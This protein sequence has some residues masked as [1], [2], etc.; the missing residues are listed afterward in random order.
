MNP[1]V[2]LRAIFPI[3]ESPGPHPRARAGEGGWVLITT[4][5]TLLLITSLG[6][7]YF[8]MVNR[9]V[10]IAGHYYRENQALHAADSGLTLA[11]NDILTN[12]L[13]SATPAQTVPATA[14]NPADA[15]VT[16]S[17]CLNA[18][19]TDAPANLSSY[20]DS[21]PPKPGTSTNLN[22]GGVGFLV[23]STGA[24]TDGASTTLEAWVRAMVNKKPY[25]GGTT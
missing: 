4:L 8:I 11:T 25:Y 13:N 20:T 17:Y 18:S 15:S 12:V 22:L 16:Y 5:M 2:I 6:I 10:L 1:S 7:L 23:E 24:T 9:D 19:C 14:V 21:P 3:P